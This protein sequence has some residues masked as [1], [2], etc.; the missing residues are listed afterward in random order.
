ML[1]AG[2]SRRW[3][4]AIGHGAPGSHRTAGS[5]YPGSQPA[6][7]KRRRPG[8]ESSSAWSLKHKRPRRDPV[9]CSCPTSAA[10]VGI[11]KPDACDRLGKPARAVRSRLV[12]V[13]AGGA[14]RDHAEGRRP[15]TG[16]Q[17]QRRLTAGPVARSEHVGCRSRECRARSCFRLSPSRSSFQQ[18]ARHGAVNVPERMSG[19]GVGQDKFLNAALSFLQQIS[20]GSPIPASEQLAAAIR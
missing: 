10:R 12:A 2:T 18:P 15:L 13:A 7:A 3:T 8:S 14:S 5:R 20:A 9:N 6:R 1:E 4:T 17:N 11:R 16:D 19:D